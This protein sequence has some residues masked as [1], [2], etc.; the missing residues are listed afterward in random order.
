MLCLVL[1][2]YKTGENGDV[3]LSCN[4][5]IIRPAPAMGQVYWP[6]PESFWPDPTLAICV[7]A[8]FCRYLPPGF[9]CFNNSRP[10][11]HAER[12]PDHLFSVT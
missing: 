7:S 2:P 12:P 6:I 8:V 4:Q 3:Q 11:A 9:C 1:F 10:I 5:R